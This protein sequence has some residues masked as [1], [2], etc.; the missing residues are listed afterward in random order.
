MYFVFILHPLWLVTAAAI[1]FGAV[2]KAGEGSAR[3]LL[4]AR[5]LS[6]AAVVG[7]VAGLWLAFA[8]PAPSKAL[9]PP[10]PMPLFGWHLVLASVVVGGTGLA[11][12]L[13]WQWATHWFRWL[14]VCTWLLALLVLCGF[15][16][17]VWLFQDITLA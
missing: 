9:P 4:V 15:A 12:W 2:R 6:A 14:A 8:H 10:I 3:W 1:Q 13:G 7:L 16:V 5:V 17:L 11:G